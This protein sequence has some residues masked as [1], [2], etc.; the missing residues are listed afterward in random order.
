MA[1]FYVANQNQVHR[2]FGVVMMPRQVSKIR[3][4]SDRDHANRIQLEFS[5]WEL[6]GVPVRLDEQPED[7]HEASH[8]SKPRAKPKTKSAK[9]R[10]N[11]RK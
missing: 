4:I 8:A 2:S 11:H 1:E 10:G 6:D 7:H 5:K 3:P 9:T